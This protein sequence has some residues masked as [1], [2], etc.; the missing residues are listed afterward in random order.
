MCGAHTSPA[1]QFLVR[2]DPTVRKLEAIVTIEALPLW[3]CSN[4]Q[5]LL[6]DQLHGPTSSLQKFRHIPADRVAIVHACS[7]TAG[8]S[9]RIRRV[10]QDFNIRT[11]FRSGP[12][13]RGLLTKVKD[14]LPIKKQ[15]NVVY[16][17]PCTCGQV[18]IGETRRRLGTRLKEHR[19]TCRKGLTDKSA[20]AEHAW[21]N[22]HPIRWDATKVLQRAS[23]T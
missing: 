15:A 22:G 8:V 12:T 11:V 16:E 5:R 1:P 4:A 6:H 10:C 23:R 21:T 13:L 9:E 20:V 7:A 19:D 18:Y 3:F 17:V 14:P 2:G